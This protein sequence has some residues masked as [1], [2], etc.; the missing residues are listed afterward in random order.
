MNQTNGRDNTIAVRQWGLDRARQQWGT[1]GDTNLAKRVAIV[2]AG[3]MGQEI[4]SLLVLHKIKTMVADA[5][6]EALEQGL[7]QVGELTRRRYGVDSFDASLLSTFEVGS[8]LQA[9]VVVESVVENM[10]VKQQVFKSLEATMASSSVLGTNTSTIQLKML[11][12]SIS[13]KQRFCGIHFLMPV[14]ETEL[15]EIIRSP[16]TDDASIATAVSLALAIDR[17][18]LV[19]RDGPGFV[20][21]R[22]LSPYLDEAIKMLCE[23][24][25][26]ERIEKASTD[27]GLPFGP[28]ELLDLIGLETAF[29]AGASMFNAFPKRFTALP[30][31]PALIKK[32]R[33]GRKTGLGFYKYEEGAEKGEHDPAMMDVIR[34]F[35]TESE[36]PISD[37]EIAARLIY[38][39][40]LEA[41]MILDEELVEDPRDI[42]LAAM[43]GLRLN[44]E[45]GGLLYWADRLGLSKIVEWADE[46]DKHV[47]SSLRDLADAQGSF[48]QS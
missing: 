1:P 22:L 45:V 16:Q 28:F 26:I 29:A 46:H 24:V 5:N 23:G 2:G 20:V 30:V 38:T 33:K 35:V 6:A 31:V 43:L 8:D 21:N 12:S 44:P 19:T 9:D 27:F 13:H 37:E 34:R 4:A 41:A 47:P 14:N 32:K 48:Y 42:E 10:F 7:Q 18:P 40:V 36:T 17:V 39:M 3:L 11:D 15:V 25:D